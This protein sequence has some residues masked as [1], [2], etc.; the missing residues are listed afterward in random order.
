MAV[1][2]V[3]KKMTSLANAIREKTGKAG[4]LSIDGMIS[5]IS[6]IGVDETIAHANIPDYV[7]TEALRVA[8]E[9]Q[10]VLTDDS[11]VFLSMS[12][13]HHPGAQIETE[14]TNTSNLHAAM[15]AKILSYVLNFD[16][17]A[18][19]GDST[20]GARTT[21]PEVLQSQIIDMITLFKESHD[22]LP[23][24]HAIGNHDTG[25]YYHDQM[26]ETGNSGVYT[27]DGDYLYSKYTA[28]SESDDTVVG[29]VNNGGYCYRDFHSK[30]LRVFLLNTSE[31]LIANQYDGG[32]LGSQRVWFANALL[33]LNSKADATNWKFIV[34]SHY[35]ADYGNTMPLSELLKAYVDGG[36]VTIFSED[37]TSHI[38]DFASANSAQFIAQ[39]HGHVHNFKTDK[40][41]IYQDGSAIS[42]DAWRICIPNGQYDR[43]NYYTYLPAYPDIDFSEEETYSKIKDSAQD[44]SFV[45]NVINPSEQVIHSICY[46]A[47]YDREL[48][49]SG[50]NYYSITKTLSNVEISNNAEQ[51]A[52]GQ[53]YFAT[54]TPSAYAT[55]NH[56]S[57]KMGD[58]D[59][60]SSA[61]SGNTISIA[62]VTDNIIIVVSASIEGNVIPD[63]VDED[64][65]IY[66][67]IGYLDGY[68]LNSSGSVV[69]NTQTVSTVTGYIPF[70]YEN[71]LR[72]IGGIWDNNG[73]SYICVY[74]S[75]RTLIQAIN[76]DNL[77]KVSFGGATYSN[78]KLV[79]KF[80]NIDDT[81][82][83]S[84][85]KFSEAAYI[86]ISCCASGAELAALIENYN[87][88]NTYS[89]D[90]YLTN[91]TTNNNTA[92]INLGD[93]Y[94]ATLTV[95][96]G[97]TLKSIVITMAG[98]D[99]TNSVYLDGV[100]N[101]PS[102][103][104]NISITAIASSDATTTYVNEIPRS[105]D[106]SGNIYG[107]DYNGDGIKDGYMS[108]YR[109]NSNCAAESLS[110]SYVTGYIPCKTGDIVYLKNITF[111]QG[112]NSGLTSGN[113][114]MAFYDEKKQPINPS[115]VMAIINAANISA[116]GEN[117][118]TVD[119]DGKWTSFTI[120]ETVTINGVEVDISNVKF[121]RMNC[122]YIG[123]DSIISINN[124]IV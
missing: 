39:F 94:T 76:F 23:C 18:H 5:E 42:Y 102:V 115:S 93:S 48:N 112:I 11:I 78:N 108:G 29:G 57:V 58:S 19:L 90:N 1:F 25:I 22:G 72:V 99:I 12:D 35:P 118:V 68:R 14:P 4:K 36:S 82:T 64:G 41:S 74:N 3:N 33:D 49:Y 95:S 9:V 67:G 59:I 105:T 81:G 120:A 62:E 124:E 107:G 50:A 117:G 80:S 13:S 30:K 97:C 121:F 88:T 24:F 103:A 66:N 26:I 116:F 87:S 2:E 17:I 56:V 54:I 63:S 65:A 31:A 86:R 113:Q 38:V 32:T 111:Q 73:A 123:T 47:G 8:N 44:T 84:G 104:G 98:T 28:L 6:S 106:D 79:W 60:T 21:T 119:D 96:D 114:R 91:V 85:I 75:D 69:Q 46:G 70:N 122:S 27:E 100:I 37:E 83:S 40:L 16:F 20:W 61:Y 55:I 51:I 45:V 89:I 52:A 7:K 43:E 109:L 110:D 10:S 92:I 34:L 77:Q 101:I 71:T 15:A 53:S